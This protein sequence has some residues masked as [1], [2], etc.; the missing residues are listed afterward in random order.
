VKRTCRFSLETD[1][2]LEVACD[3]T[4]FQFC[5]GD[6]D[7]RERMI[8][9]NQKHSPLPSQIISIETGRVTGHVPDDIDVKKISRDISYLI[10]ATR[11]NE[12][13]MLAKLLEWLPVRLQPRDRTRDL[14]L[15][16]L[17]GTERD[18]P[19]GNV[20]DGD[21]LLLFSPKVDRLLTHPKGTHLLHV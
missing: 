19:L 13:S 1:E 5:F 9:L 8:M 6:I 3:K 11:P 18:F 21:E 14:R 16:C 20:S 17:D 7:K 10:Y 2:M 15:K 4:P 12:A